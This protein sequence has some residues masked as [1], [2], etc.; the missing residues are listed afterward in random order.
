MALIKNQKGAALAVALV[1]MALLTSLAV[2]LVYNTSLDTK[3]ATAYALKGDA[4]NRALGGLDEFVYQQKSQAQINLLNLNQE[5]PEAQMANTEAFVSASPLAIRKTAC[6][7]QAVA[8][9]T[10]SVKC[11]YYRLESQ[12]RYGR[13]IGTQIG[14]IQDRRS[15][16]EGQ[17]T[18]AIELVVGN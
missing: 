6:P 3:M 17:S 13:N 8:S 14:V 2:T 5:M 10:T 4:T 16:V 12:G 7:R 11:H 15:A 18:I 1:M 9:D